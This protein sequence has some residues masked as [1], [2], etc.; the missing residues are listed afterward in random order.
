MVRGGGG[1]G[2]LVAATIAQLEKQQYRQQHN[3]QPV[4]NDCKGKFILFY[5]SLFFN[6]FLP[7]LI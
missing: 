1:G 7:I 5:F 2:R 3:K 6:Y 4:D